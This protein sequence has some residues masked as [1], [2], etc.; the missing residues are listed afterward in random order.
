MAARA[1][2]VSATSIMVNMAHFNDGLALARAEPGLQIGLHLNLTCGRPVCPPE[3]V[4]S[5]VTRGGMFHSLGNFLLRYGAGII[6]LLDVRRELDA[7][8]DILRRA[9]ISTAH[10]DSHHHV[11]FLPG[12]ARVV[13]DAA[14]ERSISRIR[15]GRRIWGS[16]GL[17]SF[18]RNAALRS[19]AGLPRAA[20]HPSMTD[21]LIMVDSNAPRA[22]LGLFKA[23]PKTDSV[24]FVCHP[25]RMDAELLRRDPAT[26]DRGADAVLLAA[27]E[28][29]ELMG[30]RTSP[31]ETA[32]PRNRLEQK[33][34]TRRRCP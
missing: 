24:E 34:V 20:A 2:V 14:R 4:D 10:I 7:Q 19:L 23:L 18:V 29:A 21:H 25:G 17:R 33:G 31:W 32:Q 12:L 28:T 26:P 22:S 8:L 9:G 30:V 1:G 13:C 3:D 5:L 6:D 16:G 11:H 27:S 15:W